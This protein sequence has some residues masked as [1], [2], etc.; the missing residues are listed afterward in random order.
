MP[1][2]GKGN[3]LQRRWREILGFGEAVCVGES[4]VCSQKRKNEHYSVTILHLYALANIK[5]YCC[6][7]FVVFFFPPCILS[8]DY[9]LS[10]LA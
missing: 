7:F 2:E 3:S 10:S 4:K 5:S 9:E 6:A 1:T 8:K